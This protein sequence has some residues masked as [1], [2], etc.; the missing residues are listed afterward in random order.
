LWGNKKG[1]G[2]IPK[3][4]DVSSPATVR[5]TSSEDDL[6]QVIALARKCKEIDQEALWEDLAIFHGDVETC[7][8]SKMALAQMRDE[9]D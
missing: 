1:A 3:Y 4:L 6:M 9:W 2:A 5:K 8:L 7:G